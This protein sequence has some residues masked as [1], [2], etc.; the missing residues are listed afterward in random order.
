MSIRISDTN[1]TAEHSRFDAAHEL[2]HLVLHRHGPP[3]GIEAERQANAFASAFLMPHGSVFPRA[4]KFPT[5]D[6]WKAKLGCV[7]GGTGLPFTQ[8]GLSKRLI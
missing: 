7:R 2:G 5:Y 8:F 4:P 6:N 1:K 3:R